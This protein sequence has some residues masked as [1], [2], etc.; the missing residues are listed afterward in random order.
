MAYSRIRTNRVW[1]TL[2]SMVTAVAMD[3][4]VQKLPGVRGGSYTSLFS[5][6]GHSACFAS[7]RAVCC[8]G[9]QRRPRCSS[10]ANWHS[11]ELQYLCHERESSSASEAGGTDFAFKNKVCCF[12][13]W[14]CASAGI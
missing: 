9:A 7:A 4:K 12:R 14:M 3:S 6:T 8:T 11:L 2:E 13:N 10:D 1:H 5:V